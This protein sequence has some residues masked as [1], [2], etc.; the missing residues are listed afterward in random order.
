MIQNFKFS[1]SRRR[2]FGAIEA[3]SYPGDRSDAERVKGP[4]ADAEKSEI[5][6]HYRYISQNIGMEMDYRIPWMPLSDL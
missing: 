4:D 5:L 3:A 2:Q 1:Q 6:N